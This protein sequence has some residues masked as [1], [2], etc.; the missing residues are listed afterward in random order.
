MAHMAGIPIV[1]MP[2]LVVGSSMVGMTLSALLAKHGVRDCITIE[3]HSSTAIHPRAALFH[4][5]TMQIYR[6]L[7]MYDQMYNESL[8]HYDEHAGLHAVE[9]LAGKELGT[10][11][12][13]INQWIENISPTSRLFLTQQMFEPLL[14]QHAIDNGALLRLSTELL[15]FQQD[16]EGVTALIRDLDTGRKELVRAKF[17]VACDGSKSPIRE[18]LGIKMK[19]HGLLSHSLTIYFKADLG[20]YVQGKYNGVIYVN[21]DD[22]RGFFRLDKTGREGFLVVNTAGKKGTEESKHP[23]IGI[24]NEKAGEMLRSAIGADVDFEITLLSPWNGLCDVAEHFNN[25]RVILAGD[26][27][28]VVTPNGGFGGNTGIHDAHNLAWK[29]ALVL[30]D[31]AGEELVTRTYHDERYPIAKKTVD[32]VFERYVVRTAPDLRMD[33]MELEEEVPEPHLELGYRYHSRALTT[34]KLSSVTSDPATAKATPGSLAHH[35]L[36]KTSDQ[37]AAFPIADL[38]G[39]CYVLIVGHEGSGWADATDAL[40]KSD[41]SMPRIVTYLLSSDNKAFYHKYEIKPGGCVLIR[42]DGVVAWSDANAPSKGLAAMGLPDAEPTIRCV[43]KQILCLTPERNEVRTASIPSVDS[44]VALSQDSEQGDLSVALHARETALKQEK[45]E[46]EKRLAEVEQSLQDVR[47]L[48]QLQN[49]MA[50]LAVR[51]GLPPVTQRDQ[52]LPSDNKYPAL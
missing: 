17:M 47:K 36:L 32:Q 26:S 6:E 28:H 5:R 50:L 9:S 46:L 31:K 48:G 39:S 7:G 44:A 45:E 51:L 42:P 1:E 43:M 25:G 27:A 23:S 20:E 38:L 15:G 34:T 16:E 2:V 35:V 4:P 41:R 40:L 13:D 24:T 19:G 12:A 33:D 29:L 18:K 21:N 22:T 14:R 30:Q 8:K 3:R 49:D 11:M 10:W 37:K 52:N